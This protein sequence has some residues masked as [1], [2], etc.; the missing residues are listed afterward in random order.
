MRNYLFLAGLAAVALTT[1][2]SEDFDLLGNK[3]EVTLGAS[4]TAESTR[5][6]F[7]YDETSKKAS[8]F[9]NTG[10]EIGVNSTGNATQFSS[11]TLKT[12][13]GE[14]T[15]TFKGNVYGEVD[16]TCYA[17]YPYNDD[18]AMDG[19]KLTYV[20][21]D[22]YTYTKVG[23]TYFPGGADSNSFNPALWAKVTD[24]GLAF[25]HLGGV[26]LVMVGKMPCAAGKLEFSAQENMAGKSV[27]DLSSTTPESKNGDNL[28]DGTTK[29][30]IN[31]SN[32]TVDQD[33]VFYIP[34]PTGTY[35]NLRVKIFENGNEKAVS[36]IAAGTFTIA[37][38]NLYRLTLNGAEL[39]A[40]ETTTVSTASEA[41]NALEKN[42]NVAVAAITAADGAS[43]ES[44]T[45][46]TITIP[47]VAKTSTSESEDESAETA[48]V[49]K[50]V[51]VEEITENVK[52]TLKD[53][54]ES[55][56]SGTEETTKKSVDAVT[57]SIPNI[58]VTDDNK[59]KLP[60]VEV[61]MPSS[62]VTLAGNAGV[63]NFGTVTAETAE[64]TLVVSSGV[65]IQK[66][67]VKKGNV[68]IESG[69]KVVAIEKDASY[70]GTPIIYV[71]DGASYP[72]DLSGFTVMKASFIDTESDFES[73]MS[74][75]GE[76]FML[77]KNLTLS[78]GY[79]TGQ[80][81]IIDLN[82]KTLTA[83]N[84]IVASGSLTLKNGKI[85]QTGGNKLIADTGGSLSVNNITYNGEDNTEC[86]IFIKQNA[87]NASL[88]VNNSTINGGY[89]AVTTNATTNPIADYCTITLEGSKFYANETGALLNI[90]ASVKMYNCEFSGNH[91]G[92][93][94]RG[95]EYA[96]SG[97]TFTLNAELEATHS[98]NNWMKI[99]QS[100]NRGA[101]AALT[102]GNYLNTAYQYPTNIT[103][104]T[105]NS[106]VVSGD[107]ASS[108]PAIH[109]C[110]NAADDKGVTITNL[111]NITKS[112]GKAEVE[113]GTTNITV[114]NADPVSYITD[115]SSFTSAM[116]NGGIYVL[117]DNVSLS[118][119]A[120]EYSGFITGS[121]KTVVID[122]NGKTLTAPS[123]VY[124]R[125]GSLTLNNGNIV[126][127][128]NKNLRAG[129]NGTLT[130][131]H[132]VYTGQTTNCCI[133]VEQQT[134]NATVNVQNSTI[135]C[136]D[137]AV[138]TNATQNNVSSNCVLNLEKST[139]TASDGTGALINI[140][141]K[142]TM[143]NCKFSGNHQGALLRGGEYAISGCTF[144]LNAESVT[145]SHQD[146]K[147]MTAW[148]SGN[149]AAFA[150]LTIG[151]Y[152]NNAYQYE[153]KATFTGTNKAIVSGTNKSDFPAIHVCARSATYPVTIT[154]F[155]KNMTTEGG[156]TP[157]IEYGTTN[158][159]VD[160]NTVATNISKTE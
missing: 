152:E 40:Q 122:L 25:K 114:D 150:A 143:T 108:F 82:G 61:T 32:A 100:G 132:V 26:F 44:P 128:N 38:R 3:H 113:Y 134:T 130:L 57:L 119:Q 46:A 160:D 123:K 121:G 51:A 154:G 70:A 14:A 104:G 158:I 6:A 49:T 76:S 27:V 11:F 89:Y 59:E 109:V 62:T 125:N 88:Y 2:C 149:A 34:V 56:S 129:A 54:A 67:I 22:S 87:Q 35:T 17:V 77:T 151:N 36:N 8:F 156:K 140:P 48:T 24:S 10:D 144:T 5:A 7:S 78:R 47:E 131:D 111:N 133:F 153:T 127:S 13:A 66:L 79:T 15:A 4:V 29:V 68:R 145:S 115:E 126:Q 31:F 74:K 52:I 86:C 30:T 81:V 75:G 19:S 16:N 103:F 90:P 42:N 102:I 95:G 28:T 9:W 137:Y 33:G 94:L 146:N 135:N 55:S 147:W 116:S 98:E 50:T 1:S 63:A 97:C 12:G 18:H 157:A 64:N 71:E 118:A 80:N 41:Q 43:A 65:T 159:T 73:A 20:F 53:A 39:S 91:Q 60:A 142:V 141:A 136:V 92:A 117:K 69:A 124:A 120:D 99:W 85:I 138:G 84:I 37:R 155:A 96:I 93:F 148:G 58:P 23:Q 105:G 21:P 101:F 107:N 110:A 106:A 83:S 112:G 139:F 45:T 72:S